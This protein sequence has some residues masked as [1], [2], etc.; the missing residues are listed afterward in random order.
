MQIAILGL[1][2]IARKAYLPL[3]GN[4]PGLDIVLFNRSL[5]PMQAIQRQ[6]RMPAAT[7]SLDEIIRARPQA[8]FVLTPK[9]AHFEIVRQL[10][11]AE[12]DVFVEKPAALT[13]AETRQLA[14]T[15]DR[16]GRVLMVAF[17]RRFAPLHKQAREL[18]AGAPVSLGL[19]QK[20]RGSLSGLGLVDQFVEDTIHQVDTLRFYC[21]EG[22]VVST[23]YSL[24]EDQ[25]AQAASTVALESGGI[26]VLATSLQAGGWNE[27]YALHAPGRSCFIDAFSRL[28]LKT[29]TEEKAWE[30]TY[31]SSWKTTL[32]GRGFTGQVDHFFECVEKR[33]QPQTSAWDSVKTQLLLEQM[34]AKAEIH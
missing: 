13:A 23:V 9:E 33:Q 14:E 27:T 28:R 16:R 31:A 11:E 34:L 4:R 6:Y 2:D 26:A 5:A 21:G 1:G 7:Q 18:M 3:L 22:A 17:N 12:I 30:E 20:Q 25:L 10:L 15:A 8:A 19:F 24:R 29:P 32:D